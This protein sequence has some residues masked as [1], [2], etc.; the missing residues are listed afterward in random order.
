MEHSFHNVNHHVDSIL[1]YIF[2]CL[3]SS[4]E[5]WCLW[6]NIKKINFFILY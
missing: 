2:T 4:T 1:K 5:N 6:N 3:Y